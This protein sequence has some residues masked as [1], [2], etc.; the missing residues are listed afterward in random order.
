MFPI[1]VMGSECS[2]AKSLLLYDSQVMFHRKL[3]QDLLFIRLGRMQQ[4]EF[5]HDLEA[6]AIL[7]T[8]QGINKHV[9][10]DC[11]AVCLFAI[12]SFVLHIE[13]SAKLVY[14]NVGNVTVFYIT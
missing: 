1:T 6:N 14:V 7:P 13:P 12:N 11:E 9:L 3:E 10:E 4:G 8:E 5:V 2:V